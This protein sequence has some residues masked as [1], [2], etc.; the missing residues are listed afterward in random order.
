VTEREHLLVPGFPVEAVDTTGAGDAFTAA[1]VIGV[2][3]GLPW[4]E[5]LRRANAA[6]AIA[7]TR[8]GT[9]VAMPSRE[10]VESFLATRR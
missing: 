8:F 1:L 3:E 6:G 10:E 2:A 4:G 7:V 5:A 9:M